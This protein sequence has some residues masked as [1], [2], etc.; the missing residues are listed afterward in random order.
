MHTVFRNKVA[1]N[2]W[3]AR[4]FTEVRYLIYCKLGDR[5]VPLPRKEVSINQVENC[6]IIVY[7]KTLRLQSSTVGQLRGLTD[8]TAMPFEPG[9]VGLALGKPEMRQSIDCERLEF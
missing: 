1:G 2:H 9:T 7:H 6:R 3:P 5:V 4:L 8:I